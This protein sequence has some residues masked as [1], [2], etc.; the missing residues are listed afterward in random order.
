MSFF[1]LS[2]FLAVAGTIALAGCVNELA[3]DELR[4][5]QPHG[6]QFSVALFKNYRALAR[7][8]GS[9][10]A[11]AGAAFDHGGSMELTEMDSDVGA[12]ANSYAQKALIAARG[13]VV[14]PEPGIDI[15]THKMRDRVVRALERGKDNF[16]VDAA[17]AQADY[18]C[19]MMNATVAQMKAASTRC[20]ASLEISL[21]KLENEARPAAVAP[22]PPPPAN[23]DQPSANPTP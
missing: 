7:S 22:A 21:T 13:S 8:F 17:R 15:A 12:L 1:S 3:L 5:A 9:V 14:E 20:R 16:P 11:A 18:D 23:S 10:G 6:S 2:R 4:D 19:W